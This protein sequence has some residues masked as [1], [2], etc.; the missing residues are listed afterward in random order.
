MLLPL[1][2]GWQF[3]R[4]SLAHF[5]GAA[6][7]T[8]LKRAPAGF[9]DATEFQRIFHLRVRPK[10]ELMDYLPKAPDENRSKPKALPL[11][12]WAPPEEDLML[13]G[14][15]ALLRLAKENKDAGEAAEAKARPA[16]GPPTDN[17]ILVHGFPGWPALRERIEWRESVTP[18]SQPAAPEKVESEKAA[19]TRC[20]VHMVAGLL[21]KAWKGGIPES[22]V[23]VVV[24]SL[25]E[26][27]AKM[28]VRKSLSYE[29]IAVDLLRP[30]RDCEKEPEFT[31]EFCQLLGLTLKD[32][33]GGK[34]K[35]A[36]DWPQAVR[37]FYIVVRIN[38]AAL[39]VY[40]VKPPVPA[41]AGKERPAEEAEVQEKAWLVYHKKHPAPMDDALQGRMLG[42]NGFI[43]SSLADWLSR[44]DLAEVGMEGEMDP[45]EKPGRQGG[46]APGWLFSALARAVLM[47]VAATERGLLHL[48]FWRQ[49]EKEEDG[50]Y[51]LNSM[52]WKDDS[53][54]TSRYCEDLAN[55]LAY[56]DETADKIQ[57]IEIEIRLAVSH[58]TQWFLAMER[59]VKA[60]AGVAADR[61][62]IEE[63]FL[64][65]AV[66]WLREDAKKPESD[67]PVIEIGKL[68]LMDRRE[69]E[70][71]LGIRDAFQRYGDKTIERPLN[72]AVFGAPG[73]GKSFGVKEVTKHLAGRDTRFSKDT[74]TFNV[75][76]FT[77]L[78]DLATA[79][80]QVRSA[81]LRGPMPVVFMDEFDSA[82]ENRPFGWL[83]YFLAPMQDGEFSDSGVN[84][85]LGRCVLVFA[86]GVNRSFEELN[87]RLRN[88]SF[89]EAKGPDFISR[90]RAHLN[91]RGINKPEDEVDQ[92]RYILR[93]A[94]MLRWMV[95]ERLQLR[96]NGRCPEKLMDPAL[97]Y[98][99]SKVERFKHGARSMEAILDMCDLHPGRSFGPSDLP[100]K[101]QLDMHLDAAKF[102]DDVYEVLQNKVKWLATA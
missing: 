89:V 35:R 3:I 7:A 41:G 74:L 42:Y 73:A 34:A 94:I 46:R 87:G 8:H 32:G 64:Q 9:T 95:R 50:W 38:S 6:A 5:M 63:K 60:G 75:S 77:G 22:Q 21:P 78:A 70:D 57:A 19:P 67:I 24:S 93:R 28:R 102:L 58:R 76:Q 98:A 56:Q 20:A 33:T 83:K 39:F 30:W 43:S 68:S 17:D 2:V 99:F 59:I 72:I 1:R 15:D 80:H 88:P 96:G 4:A 47:Q 16:D 61:E 90:L 37:V 23:R 82:F 45:G 13:S 69:V 85:K 101:A 65:K 62:N 27:C 66:E 12:E 84:Y 10:A 40:R 49:P 44:L 81:C 52:E 53:E 25:D 100:A 11:L 92:D 51:A 71:Y 48:L 18:E 86:G 79:L 91:I 97:A 14:L 29:S 55:H 36:P 26:I 54:D 31:K